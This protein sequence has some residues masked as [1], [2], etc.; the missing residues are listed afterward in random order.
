ML[1]QFGFYEAIDFTPGRIQLKEGNKEYAIVKSYMAHHQ[2][3]SLVAMN[4]VLNDNIMQKRFHENVFVKSAEILLQEKIPSDVI[5][6]KDSKEKVVP[7]K[8]VVVE[9]IDTDRFITSI[10]RP[11]SSVNVLT[12]GAYYTVITDRGL[13]YSKY[14]Y[15]DI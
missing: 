6:T 10:G 12:N 11:I 15:I 5:Y 2:G 7:P 4:N 13:G 8:Q 14:L 9:N 3:M 1:G